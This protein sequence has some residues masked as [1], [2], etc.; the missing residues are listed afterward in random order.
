MAPLAGIRRSYGVSRGLIVTVV[1]PGA[2]GRENCGLVHPQRGD[3]C[4]MMPPP[5]RNPLSPVRY[6]TRHV[7]L[8]PASTSS[9]GD[10]SATP[11]PSAPTS[12]AFPF[13]SSCEVHW[14]R[15]NDVDR[16]M[17]S[18][19]QNEHLDLVTLASTRSLLSLPHIVFPLRE[20]CYFRWLP[21]ILP[22]Q[23]PVNGRRSAPR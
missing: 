1:Y 13:S 9:F 5:F 8:L 4:N 17:T 19:S 15:S 14:M 12:V 22:A 21:P 7:P 18:S 10:I 23:Q 2:C 16:Q 6:A 3:T 20:R 11:S